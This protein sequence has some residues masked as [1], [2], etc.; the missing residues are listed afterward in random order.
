MGKV[1]LLENGHNI[2][3][4]TVYYPLETENQEILLVLR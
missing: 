2:F 1:G 4:V 3:N